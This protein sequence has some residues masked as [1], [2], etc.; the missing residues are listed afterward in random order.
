M[1]EEGAETP[2]DICGAP[3]HDYR[4]CPGGRYPESQD[5]TQNQIVP[6]SPYCGW[7]QQYG[8]ISKDCLVRHY[9]DSMREHFP[10]QEK[11]QKKPLRQ[12]DCRQCGQKHLFNVYC[13]YITQPPVIP[14]ECKSCGA[15]TNTH[16]EDCQ[17]VQ[18]KDEIG[19]CSYCGKLDHSY[20][21]CPQ[22]EE[23]KERL[24]KERKENKRNQEKGKPR[25][26]IVSGV[27][28]Q[29]RDSDTTTP[30]ETPKPHLVNPS[31]QVLCSFCGS[32]AHSYADCL[33][34]QQY[35]RQQANELADMRVR[36]YH[37]TQAP[38][39]SQ[40]GNLWGQLPQPTKDTGGAEPISGVK[41]GQPATRKGDTHRDTRK[42]PTK[43][44]QAKFGLPPGGRWTT[45]WGWW[46][47]PPG[48]L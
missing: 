20:A 40:Q 26:R 9:D 36:R 2:C 15:V 12:Y 18:I 43:G 4:T 23:D 10:P 41:G 7:C 37:A 17:Y 45:P 19:I 46:R 14:G 21:K 42:F 5:P 31:I 38:A 47:R 30:S 34:L 32:D 13:P 6:E 35:V 22:R 1:E 29:R 44:W 27:I 48:W 8:H 28:T 33:M 39:I 24:R 25:V 3:D 11:K 16:D